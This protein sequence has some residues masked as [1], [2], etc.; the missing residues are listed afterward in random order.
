VAKDS[1]RP[2]QETSEQAK[3]SSDS[4]QTE[5]HLADGAVG[6]SQPTHVQATVEDEGWGLL[7]EDASSVQGG[8]ASAASPDRIQV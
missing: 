4:D 7:V 1:K 2:K 5:G 8:Q 3:G 6:S